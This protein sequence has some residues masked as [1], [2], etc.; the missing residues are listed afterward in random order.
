M[1]TVTVRISDEDKRRLARRGKISDTVRE[2]L[3]R[4]LDTEDSDAAYERLRV[5]QERYRV[6]T[7]PDE[8]VRMI[9]E[10]RYRDSG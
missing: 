10:D 7:P 2:A 1:P 6:R 4:Y 9:K 3:R 5:L 8:I